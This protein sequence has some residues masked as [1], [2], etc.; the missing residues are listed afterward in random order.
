MPVLEEYMKQLIVPLYKLALLILSARYNLAAMLYYYRR[1]VQSLY[2]EQKCHSNRERLFAN[3][4]SVAGNISG[5]Y[6]NMSI[7][8]N[9][10]SI[11]GLAQFCAGMT[12]T[13][14]VN[15]INEFIF[16]EYEMIDS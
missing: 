9:R 6:F 13:V 16:G 7:L 1:Q 11:T 2:V 14:P 5:I 8:W 3:I 10:I 4:L 15:I 12:L